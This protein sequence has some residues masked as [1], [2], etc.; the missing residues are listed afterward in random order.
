LLLFYQPYQDIRKPHLAIVGTSKEI[1]RS[2]ITPIIDWAQL[3]DS[4]PTF[5]AIV[6]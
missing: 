3:T 1:N 6:V 4:A 2:T 5:Y